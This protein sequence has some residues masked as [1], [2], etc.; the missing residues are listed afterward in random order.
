M[1]I[2]VDG[3]IGSG[4]TSLVTLLANFFADSESLRVYSDPGLTPGDLY[5][6]ADIQHSDMWTVYEAESR[7]LFETAD[8]DGT[9]KSRFMMLLY[10]A[11]LTL[12]QADKRL[13][14]KLT[15]VDTFWDPLWRLEAEHLRHSFEWLTEMIRLPAVS[16]F[17]KVESETAFGRRKGETGHPETYSAEHHA[18]IDEKRSFFCDFAGEHL[19]DFH[20]INAREPIATVVADVVSVLGGYDLHANPV[21]ETPVKQNKP[22]SREKL[23]KQ[24]VSRDPWGH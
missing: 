18:M 23:L 19:P 16:L 8:Y 11:R 4:K 10:T 15:F 22:S 9:S 2:A 1:L 24:R 7:R 20:V 13:R 12:I 21:Q 6:E 3:P 17:L 5:T 14:E